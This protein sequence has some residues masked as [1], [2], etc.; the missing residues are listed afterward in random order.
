MMHHLK[1]TACFSLPLRGPYRVP[2]EEEVM[3]LGIPQGHGLFQLRYAG[4]G[5]AAMMHPLKATACF[6]IPLR[7]I[8]VFQKGLRP[9]LHN[10][11]VFQKGLRPVL[12][13]E[14]WWYHPVRGALRA[15][16]LRHDVVHFTSCWRRGCQCIPSTPRPV[17]AYPFGVF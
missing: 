11:V 6:G 12:H 8:V 9:V 15:G 5:D 7:G 1:A 3:P 17:S 14:M 16:L 2:L 4:G 10:D 13:N